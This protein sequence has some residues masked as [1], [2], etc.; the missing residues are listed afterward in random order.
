MSTTAIAAEILE[1]SA[2]WTD[3]E[4]PFTA[5]LFREDER[6]LVI[7][8]A[9]ASGKSLFFQF[10]SGWAREEK[11][12]PVS[13]SIRERTGAGLSDIAGMRRTMM[14]GQEESQSTGACSVKVVRNG[15]HNVMNRRSI[16]M[17]DEPDMGLSEDY[18]HAFGRLIVQEHQSCLAQNPEYLGLVVV[19][20]SRG[21]V[22]GMLDEGAAPSFLATGMEK[23]LLEWLQGGERRSLE[24]LMTLNDRGIE[25][26]RTASRL[27]KA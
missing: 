10:M 6:L 20:H 13:I 5:K 2:F 9:N 26:F 12:L 14:F 4:C 17:L 25:L 18:A 15:F 24:E 16:L 21:L 1:D 3:P 27:L 23:S 19:T 11:I 22:Q 8:G 7:A